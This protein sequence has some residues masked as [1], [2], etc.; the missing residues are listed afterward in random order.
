MRI[1]DKNTD[2]YDYLQN[3][4]IDKT[5]TFDRTDSYLLTKEIMWDNM[6][7]ISSD[8]GDIVFLL[9]QVCNK[10]W[11]F[12]ITVTEITKGNMS[13]KYQIELI[14][15]WD[16]YDKKREL[17]QLAFIRFGISIYRSA[18][19]SSKLHTSEA[20][21]RSD[22]LVNAINTNDYDAY[23]NITTHAFYN[24]GTKTVKHIPI[25]KACGIADFID[26]LEIYLAFEEYFMLEKSSG[27]RTESVGLTDK[28]KIGN[29]GF[30]IK[31]SF[32]NIK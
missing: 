3:I 14:S 13:K 28:E 25:L 8:P 26:P 7:Y 32:R 1:I 29:H 12:R 10:F 23:N 30:D 24:N 19:D 17:I 11:L 21:K 22:V 9:M 4:Y 20:F 18:L 31:S 6:K 27:E 5:I 2:F 15:S 16:N